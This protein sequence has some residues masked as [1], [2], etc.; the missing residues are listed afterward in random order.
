MVMMV[1][2]MKIAANRMIPTSLN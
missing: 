1:N 2:R